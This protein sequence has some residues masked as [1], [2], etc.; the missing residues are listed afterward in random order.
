MSQPK[1]EGDAD[2]V[3]ELAV[4]EMGERMSDKDRRAQVPDHVLIKFVAEANKT[5]ERRA[6]EKERLLEEQQSRDEVEVILDSPLPV[7]KKRTLLEALLGR[8]E[9]RRNQI[10]DL[11]GEME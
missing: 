1:W 8:V 6:A 9:K 2:D 11:I 4:Q 7:D 5:A 10:L 3:I